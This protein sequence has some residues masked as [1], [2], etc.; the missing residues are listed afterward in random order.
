MDKKKGTTILV[1]VAIIL[2]LIAI[3]LN[4][5][6]NDI[7]TKMDS[8]ESQLGAGQVGVEIV[9]GGIEDKSNQAEQETGP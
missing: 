6:E 9:P 3:S 2:A 1:I 7:K 8:D 4:V 5:I